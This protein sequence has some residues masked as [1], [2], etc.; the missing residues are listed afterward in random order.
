MPLTPAYTWSETETSIRVEINNVSI[1]DQGQIFCSDRVVKLN[2][3]PYLLVLDL[4]KAVDDDK[5]LAT[6]LHGRKLVLQLVKAEPGLWG[7]LTAQGDKREIQQQREE[8]VK[9]AHAKQ[10]ATQQQRLARRQHQE[11]AAID[12]QIAQEKAQHA[13][14]GARSVAL[15]ASGVHCVA[16]DGT[17]PRQKVSDCGTEKLAGRVAPVR[18]R[19]ASVAV[20]FT[21]L[22]TSHLP[23]REQREVEIKQ[24]KRRNKVGAAS[25]GRAD[26]QQGSALGAA[27]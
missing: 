27:G 7:S 8:S 14:T 1:K 15:A 26:Q 22:E 9:R 24:I 4:N 2:A 16:L 20:S 25:G 23:A 13:S 19:A 18:S 3:A 5:S 6:V 21:S 10:A 12:L 11:R 17:N